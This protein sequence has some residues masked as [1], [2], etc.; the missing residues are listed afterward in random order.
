[1]S[2]EILKSKQYAIEK[3]G[4]QKY[5]DKEY[6]YH[7][8]QVHNLILEAGLDETYQ[9]AAFL[10]DVLEDTNTSKK[11]LEEYFGKETAHLV[12]CVSGFGSNRKE[13]NQDIKKKLALYPEARNLKLA[14]RIC[15]MRESKIDNPKLYQMYLK[16]LPEFKEM[17]IEANDYLID[18]LENEF[19]SSLK[20]KI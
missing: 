12:W 18:I 16:E 4:N 8:Q 17:I 5:G 19:N 7:L 10:H 6:I 1:M 15:N 20:M 14:D 2:D 9:K 13:R 11:E 3:H